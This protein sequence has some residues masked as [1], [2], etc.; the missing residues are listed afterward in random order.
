[1]G[2]RSAAVTVNNL[3]Q[4]MKMDEEWIKEKK[5]VD[6]LL[7]KKQFSIHFTE[8]IKEFRSPFY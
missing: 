5:L 6:G 4:I 1:M 2:L 8:S 3:I 7:K